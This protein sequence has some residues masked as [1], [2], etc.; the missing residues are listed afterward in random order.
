[1]TEDRR[2]LLEHVWRTMY[3]IRCRCGRCDCASSDP[4]A[5]ARVVLLH[6]SGS[7]RHM[8][9]RQK[10]LADGFAAIGDKDAKRLRAFQRKHGDCA[11]TAEWQERSAKGR[12][13]AANYA[14]AS[15]VYERA[16]VRYL[17]L[18]RGHHPF[19]QGAAA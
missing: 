3:T 9:A 7:F 15:R 10:R 14:H 5:L 12:E 18:S 1:M 8:A 4:V 19:R 6:W 17:R 16:C 2:N 11:A 13:Q